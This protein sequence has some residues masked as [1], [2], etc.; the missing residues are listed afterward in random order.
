MGLPNAILERGKPCRLDLPTGVDPRIHPFFRVETCG[1]WVIPLVTYHN[2][3]GCELELVF[4]GDERGAIDLDN[5]MKVVFDGLRMPQ[6]SALNHGLA[7]A[8]RRQMKNS[9]SRPRLGIQAAV[10]RSSPRSSVRSMRGPLRLCVCPGSGARRCYRRLN[11][12]TL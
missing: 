3:L 9:L 2:W 7:A 5:Q 12:Q 1:Y 11:T 10:V 6:H 8:V 4:L